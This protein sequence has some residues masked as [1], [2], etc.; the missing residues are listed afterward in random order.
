MWEEKN[1][2]ILAKDEEQMLYFI[3]CSTHSNPLIKKYI[4]AIVFLLYT[5][6]CLIILTLLAYYF[7]SGLI[8]KI[9]ISLLK[10]TLL[11]MHWFISIFTFLRKVL[12]KY[13]LLSNITRFLF[14]I[15]SFPLVY[16]IAVSFF[17]T[18][19]KNHLLNFC[20]HTRSGN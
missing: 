19:A 8:N 15:G 10:S 7:N 6:F 20:F 5:K 13:I 2:S 1:N 11:V 12:L 18:Q 16:N 14:L 9:F 17:F 4:M 3:C